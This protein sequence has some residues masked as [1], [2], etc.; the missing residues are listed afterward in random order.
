L[1]AVATKIKDLKPTPLIITIGYGNATKYTCGKGS[2]PGGGGLYNS[3]SMYV[4]DVLAAAASP[5]SSSVPSKADKATCADEN[6]DN[7]NY[8]CADGTTVN[9]SSVFEAAL[10]STKGGTKF[11]SIGGVGD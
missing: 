9:I 10:G 6:A 8:Y 7:D 11:M 3:G 2:Y 5:K 1:K 4:D